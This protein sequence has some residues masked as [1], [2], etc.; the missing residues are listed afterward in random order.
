MTKDEAVAALW[1]YHRLHQSLKP[2]DLLLVLGS[3]DERVGVYAAELYRQGLAPKVLFSG[4][5]G[6]FTEGLRGTEAERFAA[7]AEAA[8]LPPEAI[9]LETRSTNT[10]ENVRFSREIL[11]ETG[12]HP[13]S[14][15]A[16]QKPYMERRTLATLEAQWPGMPFQVSAPQMAFGEYLT[17][18]L[19]EE[20][21]ISAM[22]GDYQ[23][24]LEYPRLGFSTEQPFSTRAEEAFLTLAGLGYTSQLLR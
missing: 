6:R 19:N 1:E 24:I 2:A 4:G 10:G 3:N 16:L 9:L 23:R 20:I 13:Q 21:V 15:I 7:A 11:Q 12:L 18:T 14:I 17:E 8:G 22:V 5:A